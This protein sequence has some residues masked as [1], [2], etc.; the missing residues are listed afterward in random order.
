MKTLIIL[1]L[2][3]GAAVA[4]AG[5]LPASGAFAQ[6]TPASYYFQ[7][8]NDTLSGG[9]PIFSVTDDLVF[10]NLQINEVFTGGF[11]QTISLASL[12]TLKIDPVT[13]A[14]TGGDEQSNTFS[15]SSPL[16]SAVLTGSIGNGPA[17]TVNLQTAIGGPVTQ[18]YVSST[19]SASLF[20]PAQTGTALGTFGLL[21]GNIVTPAA[22]PEASTTVSLGLLLLLGL[23]AL[24][25][26]RR[27]AASAQ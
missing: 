8:E 4:G 7:V 14:V 25:V 22:V 3:C 27:R 15:T 6:T 18:Q 5:L 9:D 23:G 26:S 17:Q 1:R 13:S 10:S 2:A 21:D 19:F 24:A 12:T 11:S 16:T 20:G